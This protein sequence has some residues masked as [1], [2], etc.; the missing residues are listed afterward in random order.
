MRSAVPARRNC[1]NQLQSQF[2]P[3][4]HDSIRSLQRN[5]TASS[6]RILPS[7]VPSSLINRRLIVTAIGG[8]SVRDR[9][10]SSRPS[11]RENPFW[12]MRIFLVFF[13]YLSSHNIFCVGRFSSDKAFENLRSVY[14]TSRLKSKNTEFVSQCRES[15]PTSRSRIPLP[16]SKRMSYLATL[17]DTLS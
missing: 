17:F 6:A 4:M 3:R 15:R 1:P 9:K 2:I 5:F 8:R 10:S 14:E 16:F 13:F 12:E 11:A 7:I